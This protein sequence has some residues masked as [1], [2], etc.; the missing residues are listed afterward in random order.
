MTFLTIPFPLIDPV[1]IEIGPFA[2]RWYALAYIFGIF[3]GILY[4]KYLNKTSDTIITSRQLDDFLIWTLVGVIIGGRFGYVIF[5]N[6]AFY[7]NNINEIFMTWKGGMSFHGGLVGVSLAII[8][9]SHK[10]EINKWFLSDLVSCAVPI[11][12]FLGRIANFIN[13]ELY[14][15]VALNTNWAIIF[16]NAGPLP[17]HPSQLYEAALEGV[18]LFFI[19]YLF[20][21]SIKIRNNYGLLTGIFC[22]SYALLRGFCEFFREPDDHL[23]FLFYQ[24][25]M[26]QLLSALLLLFGC[27]VV[28]RTLT[29]K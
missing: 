24:L 1:L 3:G 2:I 4:M 23:G 10:L 7:I 25:T 5:Y 12:I 26:G 15:R 11:G 18:L 16:P 19:M 8:I 14:G 6:P 28:Y 21:K 20:W 17:R 13:G 29:K 22:I 9:Y 27:L